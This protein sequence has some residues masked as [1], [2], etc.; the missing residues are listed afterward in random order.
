MTDMKITLLENRAV[1]TLS[2]ADVSHFLQNLITNDMDQVSETRG[3]YAALLTAQGKFLHDF[4]V[5]K[6]GE[7]YLLDC[8][9][10]R[11]DDL[12][13][14]LTMYKL[15][16]DVAISENGEQV[17]ALFG[18]RAPT[19]A[20]LPDK[21]G[22]VKQ[23]GAA[24]YVVDPRLTAMGVR[25]IANNE[26]DQEAA[27][28]AATTALYEAYDAHRLTLGIPDGGTDILPEKNFLLEANF[29]E[30]NG[31]SFTKGCYVGQELTARTKHRA[32]IKKR[33]FQLTYDGTLNPGDK[34][35]RDGTEIAEVRSFAN[36]QG[37]A[38]VRIENILNEAGNDVHPKG[39]T[40]QTPKYLDASE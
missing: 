24:L 8:A 14:R 37:L 17:Y 10:D 13:R 34:I 33:L 3:I 28:P 35:T 40:F 12:I 6:K 15:R 18:E 30:L 23:V 7:G 2:G 36:G 27:F 4:F 19:A 5:L 21:A 32:K 1:I 38:L 20:G 9:A 22:T 29:E 26:F 39:V 11:K 16:A 25:I 31:V